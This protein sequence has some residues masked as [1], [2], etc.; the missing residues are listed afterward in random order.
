M[1]SSVRDLLQVACRI[2]DITT[3]FFEIHISRIKAMR[4]ML[5]LNPSHNFGYDAF[6][7]YPE[8]HTYTPLGTVP[9]SFVEE[10][11]VARALWRLQYFVTLWSLPSDHDIRTGL[12]RLEAFW[13]DD[14]IA[15][16]EEF[17][18]DN[19]ITLYPPDPDQP[20][21]KA[22]SLPASL[23]LAYPPLHSSILANPATD[24]S[25]KAWRQDIEAAEYKFFH[26]YAHVVSMSPLKNWTS[27]P[28]R[29]LGFTI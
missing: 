21:Q 26:G 13:D 10:L 28:F 14:E 3:L 25:S 19:H 9:A 16:L 27:R 1:L 23:T 8:G 20:S 5:L 7:G 15:C 18:V 24:P 12:L 17:L 2:H 6:V 11:R 29:R 4:P 22:S